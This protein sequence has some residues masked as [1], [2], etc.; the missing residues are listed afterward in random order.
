[1]NLVDSCGWI[2]YFSDSP[3]A[4]F[5][6]DAIE[7]IDELIVPT[8]CIA[9]VFKKLYITVNEN[10]ALIAIAHMRQ[11]KTIPLT[12]SIA[13]A[14]ATFG[15]DEKLPFAESVIYATGIISKARILTQDRYFKGLEGIQFL[16]I[17]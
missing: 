1:M 13:L 12:D 17:S 2:E 5:Y 15:I 4:D 9:E 16:D 3:N 7:D 6:A 8:V 10:S 11:G 14:A